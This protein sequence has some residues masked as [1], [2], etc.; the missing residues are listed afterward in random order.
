[1]RHPESIETIKFKVKIIKINYLKKRKF[2]LERFLQR[3]FLIKKIVHTFSIILNMGRIMKI[4][5]RFYEVYV[6]KINWR[7]RNNVKISKIDNEDIFQW[8]E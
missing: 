5:N 4:K 2:H 3:F 8:L 1:M 7:A 6:A